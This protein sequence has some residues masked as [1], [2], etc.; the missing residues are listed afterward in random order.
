MKSCRFCQKP[1]LPAHGGFAADMDITIEY[2]HW[3]CHNCP[4]T[5]KEYDDAD[6][7]FSVM[8][9]YNGNWYEVMQS[10]VCTDPKCIPSDPPL[11]SIYKYTLYKDSNSRNC[12]KTELVFELSQDIKLT[13]QN[14]DD[15]LAMLLVFS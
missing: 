13:P 14:I 7:W 9:F 6:T 12:L 8:S 1:M 4:R 15:K 11:T 2:V 10:Y 5:V 3:E